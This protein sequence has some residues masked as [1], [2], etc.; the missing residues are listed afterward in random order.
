MKKVFILSFLMLVLACTTVVA[1]SDPVVW[2]IEGEKGEYEATAVYTPKLSPG[3]TF[4]ID[5]PIGSIDIAGSDTD[6][7]KVELFLE[8][9]SKRSRFDVNEWLEK[10]DLRID[11]D[12]GNIRISSDDLPRGGRFRELDL[13]IKVT[14]PTNYNIDGSNSLGS[15]EAYNL[16]GKVDFQTATGSIEVRKVTGNIDIS[17]STGSLALVD[18]VGIIDAT[19]STGSLV[20]ENVESSKRSRISTSTG[21]CEIVDTRG[22]VKVSTSTGSLNIEGHHDKLDASTSTGR[23]SLDDVTGNIHA[24][25]S[26]GR[27]KAEVKKGGA[28]EEL[29]L[30]T[31]T[32]RIELKIPEELD[33]TLELVVNDYDNK[34]DID[35]DFELDKLKV[36]RDD[37]RGQVKLNKGTGLIHAESNNGRI[38]VW[39]R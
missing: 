22:A 33:A 30:F 29:D 35:S 2:K 12:S 25:T 8:I 4:N 21:S 15:L 9:E 5:V 3:G 1:G 38:S 24:E 39:K 36:V 16:T 6:T 26:T 11:F 14:V 31:G 13:D 32:G 23:V 17:T 7:A 19:T 20:V 18:I 10:L 27:I 34:R 28:I 37:L